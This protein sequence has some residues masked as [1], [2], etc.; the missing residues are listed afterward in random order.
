MPNKT[1]N[2]ANFIVQKKKYKNINSHGF[3]LNDPVSDNRHVLETEDFFLN[4]KKSCH[5]RVLSNL[6]CMN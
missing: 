4:K 2:T 5:E 6:N 1:Q 3:Q